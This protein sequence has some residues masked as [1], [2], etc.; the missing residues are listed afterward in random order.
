MPHKNA[1]LKIVPT[2]EF[3]HVCEE[4]R[5]TTNHAC[6]PSRSRLSY[7]SDLLLTMSAYVFTSNNG[8]LRNGSPRRCFCWASPIHGCLPPI[9]V[10]LHQ[11]IG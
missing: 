9:S 5:M 10:E 11:R 2:C 4:L 1:S 3:V 7:P 8:A 6:M